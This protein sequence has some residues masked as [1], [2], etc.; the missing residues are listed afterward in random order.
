MLMRHAAVL[1]T[2][3][4]GV[5]KSTALTELA[6]PGQ[7]LIT[8]IRKATRAMQPLPAAPDAFV[9]LRLYQ[10]QLAGVAPAGRDQP[11]WWTLREPLRA[12]R[13]DAARDVQP[14]QRRVGGELVAARSAP[15]F[16]CLVSVWRVVV[17]RVISAFL[18][19]RRRVVFLW[20]SVV[21]LMSFFSSRGWESW[22]VEHR[23]LIP[24][25]MPCWW[26]TTCGSKTGQVRRGRR[27]W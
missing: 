6:D 12:L 23:P 4:S 3:M 9:W 27:P 11:L 1:V 5:G 15:H 20:S 24:E 2:G 18:L 26:T 13:Y 22:D 19:W 14:G 25:R 8:V 7:Q 21:T 17:V 10:V 16:I